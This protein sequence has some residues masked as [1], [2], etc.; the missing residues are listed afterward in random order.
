MRMRLVLLVI[1]D[2]FNL[3]LSSFSKG[4]IVVR[5]R[6]DDVVVVGRNASFITRRRYSRL[7]ES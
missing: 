5:V 1:I 3:M 2:P 7:D 6:C 4:A